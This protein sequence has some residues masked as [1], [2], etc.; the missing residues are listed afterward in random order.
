MA[1]RNEFAKNDRTLRERIVQLQSQQSARGAESQRQNSR[2][3]GTTARVNNAEQLA[4]AEAMGAAA[5]KAAAQSAEDLR[6]LRKE[7]SAAAS[8]REMA[9][10]A[11]LAVLTRELLEMEA[12]QQ[13]ETQAAE[14]MRE[15]LAAEASHLQRKL[16]RVTRE[17][18]ARTAEENAETQLNET[19]RRNEAKQRAERARLAVRGGSMESGPV[20]PEA[21]RR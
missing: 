11:S 10:E 9:H 16:T 20:T 18:V 14:R 8:L 2:L 21:R 15:R 3:G 6:V 17:S 13:E 19:A 5:Q 12:S 7:V 4:M 1:Q